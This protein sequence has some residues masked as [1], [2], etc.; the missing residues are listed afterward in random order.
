MGE[1]NRAGGPLRRGVDDGGV[2]AHR[3]NLILRIQSEDHRVVEEGFA[4]LWLPDIPAKTVLDDRAGFHL[5]ARSEQL[6]QL[7]KGPGEEGILGGFDE[8]EP[9]A[10]E[11]GVG[12]PLVSGGEIFREEF[13][14]VDQTN[15]GA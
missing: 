5:V 1:M 6:R 9:D 14:R 11:V 8:V 12:G 7:V 10:A 4:G 13:G 2:V 3:R 15:E